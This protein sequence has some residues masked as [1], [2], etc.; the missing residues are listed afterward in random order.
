MILRDP[1]SPNMRQGGQSVAETPIV[2][3]GLTY[4]DEKP[5]TIQ[6]DTSN[7][8]VGAALI[9]D[10]VIEYHSHALT[11]PQQC[12]SNIER[13]ACTLV[14]DVE[15]FHHYIFGK[16]FEVHTDHQPLVQLSIKTSSELSPSLQCLFLRVNQYKYTVKYVRQTGVMIADCL[17]CIVCQDTAEDDETLNL[18]VAALMTFQDGKLQDIHCQTLFDPQLVK[19]ARAIQNGWGESGGDLDADLHTFLIHRFNMHIANSIIMNGSRIVVPKSLQQEYLQC[20]HMGHLG[21]SKCRARAKTTVFWPNI[22]QDINQLITR[23]DVCHEHQH[24]P[25]SYNEHSVE[26][27]FPSHIYSADLCDIDG[28]VHVVCVDCF[29]FFIWERPLPDMQ[30]DT[31]ILGLKTIFSENSSPEILITDNGWSFISEYFKQFAME[32]SFVHKMSSPRYPKGNAH[33]E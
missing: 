8:G 5:C 11:S 27:H 32:W 12:Y 14:N 9:Q 24:A 15:H 26:A 30:S 13:E 4:D 7:I 29:S 1:L 31:V 20:L 10:K 28:K 17:G 16:P 6:V 25:P 23:C 18:H 33:A 2:S 21:I 19:L 22:D 3:K